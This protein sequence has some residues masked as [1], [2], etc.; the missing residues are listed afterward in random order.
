[1]TAASQRIA[2]ATVHAAER[3][4]PAAHRPDEMTDEMTVEGCGPRGQRPH[5]ATTAVLTSCGPTQVGAVPDG[6]RSPPGASRVASAWSDGRGRCRRC[7]R[8]RGDSRTG[9][10]RSDGTRL[11]E[12]QSACRREHDFG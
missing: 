5:D 3:S 12:T 11:D 10:E 1:M 9:F 2:A 4:E 6:Q 7:R 8:C